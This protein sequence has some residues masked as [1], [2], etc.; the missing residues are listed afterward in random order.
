M[1]TLVRIEIPGR[2]ES[3]ARPGDFAGRA[4]QAWFYGQLALLNPGQA[5]ELHNAVREKP[6][7]LA[8]VRSEEGHRLVLGAYGP[9]A[10]HATA[11]A[12]SIRTRVL[13]NARWWQP[14]GPASVETA[15]W[16]ELAEPLLAPDS[17][18]LVRVRFVT[19][20]TFRSS[21]NYLPLPVPAAMF[22]SMLERW[23]EWAPVSLGDDALGAV[24]RIA[25]RRHRLQSVA[26]QMKGLVP[27]FVGAAE[28]EMRERVHPYGGLVAVLARFARFAG[29]GAKVSTGFGCVDVELVRRPE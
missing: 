5:E 22:S 28:F 9:V 4:L 21:G 14:T 1:T 19:P 8:L 10:A 27:A 17:P 16:E 13:F 15:S 23:R 20:T 2:W 26:I 18:R 11:I 12:A 6:F 3:E 29:V 25:I 7:H 24:Q